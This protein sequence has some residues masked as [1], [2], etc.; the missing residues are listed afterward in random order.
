MSTTPRMISAMEER[1]DFYP[2]HD[3]RKEWH[4]FP[5]RPSASLRGHHCSEWRE[6]LGFFERGQSCSLVLFH[7]HEPEPFAEIEFPREFRIGD[8]YSMIVFDLDYEDLEYGYRFSGPWDPQTGHRFDKTKNPRRS[9]RESARRPRCLA[10]N[11]RIGTTSIS[12]APASLSTTSTGRATRPLE[13]PTKDLIIY[14]AHVRGFTASPT[15]EVSA[16]GTF[17]GLREKIPYLKSLG[18]N[19]LELLPIYEFDEWENN[20]LH[21]ETG[22][23]LLNYWG[24]STVGFFA[25]EGRIRGH[26]RP[27]HAG[28]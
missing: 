12:I 17:A 13:I 20:R 11:S 5:A 15:S 18:I 2:T 23:L 6:L 22:E 4:P 16:P 1:I 28:G 7:K 21:P 24:Y 10:R 8:V 27:R 14:E 3:G 9:L 26:G 19:C 25:P